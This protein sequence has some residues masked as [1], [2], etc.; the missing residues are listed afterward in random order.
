VDLPELLRKIASED[1]FKADYEQITDTLLFEKLPY[2]QAITVI[3]KL[4][5][6]GRLRDA[7]SGLDK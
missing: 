5:D 1:F 3:Q 7:R 6:D 2:S 4:L